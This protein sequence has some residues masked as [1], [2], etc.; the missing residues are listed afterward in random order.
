MIE[1]VEERSW[2]RHPLLIRAAM[3]FLSLHFPSFPLLPA[4]ATQQVDADKSGASREAGGAEEGELCC[5]CFCVC[6]CSSDKASTTAEEEMLWKAR[7]FATLYDTPITTPRMY[8]N[9]DATSS[10]QANEEE[11][12][13]EGL[14][15]QWLDSA[16][17]AAAHVYAK[18]VAQIPAITPQASVCVTYAS[19]QSY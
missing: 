6:L 14:A 9:A 3:I 7:P 17:T 11:I 19:I 15:A 8:T 5:D 4:A 2:P 10:S 16:V 1:E 18:A 12:D 13:V